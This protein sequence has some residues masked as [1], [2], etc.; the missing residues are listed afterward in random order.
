LFANAEYVTCRTLLDA[1]QPATKRDAGEAALLA[2]RASRALGDAEGWFASATAAVRDLEAPPVHATALAMRATAARIL[3]KPRDAKHALEEAARA[4]ARLPALSGGGARYEL[5]LEAL[6][7]HDFARAE[8]LAR[9]NIAAGALESASTALL[10]SI[11]IKRERFADAATHFATALRKLQASGETDLALEARTLLG[12]AGVAVETVD[13][14]AIERVRK[15][16][17]KASWPATLR[18][19]RFGILIAMLY[20][21]LLENDVAAAYFAARE[22]AVVAPAA[23]DRA[24]A[25]TLSATTSALLGDRNAEKL[26]FGRAWAI[27]RSGKWQASDGAA[28]S[29][30]LTFAAEAA[31]SMLGEARKSLAL[32]RAL[33]PKV[34]TPGAVASDRRTLAFEALAAGR[35]AEAAGD[36][37]AAERLYQKALDTFEGLGYAMRAAVVALDLRRITGDAAYVTPIKAALT[38]APQAWFGKQLAAQDGP[39]ERLSPAELVVLAHLLRGDTAK[40]IGEKLERSPFTISNHTRRIFQA[41]EVNS[42]S[43]V[44]AICA[45][46]G[47][48]PESVERLVR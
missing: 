1:A 14:R 7:T 42:R 45:E 12:L 26:H 17:A 3:G 31:R 18:P 40:A 41:F 20:A 37:V 29:A 47:V 6:D 43:K 39:L 13:L 23:P 11:A 34:G 10:G 36:D 22:A 38:R 15:S 48:T 21:S 46:L 24:L 44:I 30:L 4:T 8:T 19:E 16:F 5:A 33:A 9:E 2:A 27:L 35:V 32:Y 28:A 25:E